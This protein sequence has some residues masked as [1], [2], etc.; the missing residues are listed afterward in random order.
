MGEF[1]KQRRKRTQREPKEFEENEPLRV[2]SDGADL[3][4]LFLEPSEQNPAHYRCE[5]R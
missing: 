2:V 3:R 4:A 5:T 1:A